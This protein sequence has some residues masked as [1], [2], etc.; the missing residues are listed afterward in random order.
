MDGTESQ[1]ST[2]RSD[3]ATAYADDVLHGSIIA[4]PYVRDECRRHL[5]D[6][7]PEVCRERGWRYD[8]KAVE[9]VLAFFPNVLTLTGEYEGQ[10]FVLRPYQKFILGRMFGFEQQLKRRRFRYAYIESSR[11]AGKTPLAAGLALYLMIFDGQPR[12]EIYICASKRD[13]SL[14]TFK[15]ALSM[16]QQST[17]LSERIPPVWGGE[18]ME[19]I[20]DPKTGSIL[21]PLAFESSGRGY[22]GLRPYGVIL[23][24]LHDHPSDGMVNAMISGCVKNKRSIIAAFTNSGVD[25]ESVCYR[26]REL[27]IKASRGDDPRLDNRLAYV[28]AV[29]KDDDP[30]DD[31]SAVKTN[32]ALNPAGRTDP[33][34]DDGI[35][36]YASW[37]EARDTAISSP[38]SAS[39][40][41][42]FHACVWAESYGSWLGA[43][44]WKQAEKSGADLKIADY[45]GRRCWLGA[46]FALR[47]CMAAIVLVFESLHPECTYDVFAKFWMAA[48]VIRDAERRDHREGLY[49]RWK[50][51]G[52]L[53]APPGDIIDYQ[54]MATHMAEIQRSYQV[55]GMAYDRRYIELLSMEFPRMA[56]P[57]TYPM[58]PHPQGFGQ[59]LPSDPNH[60]ASPKLYMPASIKKTELLLRQKRIRVAPN[61]ILTSHV[62]SA[63]AI[64][65]RRLS[66]EVTPESAEEIRLDSS[67]SSAYI[68]GAIGLVQAVG[69]AEAKG[70]P[71]AG[72]VIEF[73]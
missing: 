32:P 45:K 58:V 64:P 30:F 31:R 4:G 69:F 67:S 70:K 33:S 36:G 52:Y 21:R 46:D 7:K 72:K 17:Y 25:K 66:K 65:N 53:N 26:E 13:Q 68:D 19:H 44:V 12:G 55:I 35:P 50:D 56:K 34:K 61:P 60:K 15:D 38:A 39:A 57:P 73:W 47:R 29:D 18:K 20:R 42:R 28:C 6:I 9:R 8:V 2:A 27:A 48:G 1:L 43:G 22:V 10:P 11:G 5:H 59:P 24:E 16:V 23:D 40:F 51:E 54:D 63:V 71:R 41:K 14:I 62:A 37:R 3:E 49:T